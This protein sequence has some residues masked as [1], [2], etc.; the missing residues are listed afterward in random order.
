MSLLTEAQRTTVKDEV[1]RRLQKDIDAD[2]LNS[3][4]GQD[5]WDLLVVD[6]WM[7]VADSLEKLE[8]ILERYL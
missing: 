1:A 3:Q 7:R 2:Q 6:A 8:P 4:R 5:L